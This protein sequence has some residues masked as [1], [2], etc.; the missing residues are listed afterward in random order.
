M[1]LKIYLV[2]K[3]KKN[4]KNLRNCLI[5]YIM[6]KIK[7]VNKKGEKKLKFIKD[8]NNETNVFYKLKYVV[9]YIYYYYL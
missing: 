5:V 9:E 3:N 6:K 8:P 7:R 1:K 4:L 2:F